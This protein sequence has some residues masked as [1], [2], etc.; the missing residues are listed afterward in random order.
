MTAYY[1]VRFFLALIFLIFGLLLVVNMPP[2]YR[3]P[4]LVSGML[5]V[6]FLMFTATVL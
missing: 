3:D 2:T 1:I 6:I 4:L 5:L